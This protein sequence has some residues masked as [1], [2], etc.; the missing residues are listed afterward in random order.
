[1]PSLVSYLNPFIVSFSM[2]PDGGYSDPMSCVIDML[3][4]SAKDSRLT[5]R[6]RIMIPLHMRIRVLV[7]NVRPAAKAMHV[8]PV[9]A[10]QVLEWVFPAHDPGRDAT[11]LV[12]LFFHA[13]RRQCDGLVYVCLEESRVYSE[14]HIV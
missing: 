7:C 12:C 9:P 4:M 13:K 6:D 3:M 14:R 5:P 11:L 1:M 8:K 2:S 10:G